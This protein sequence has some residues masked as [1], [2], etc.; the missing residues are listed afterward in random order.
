MKGRR[1]LQCLPNACVPKVIYCRMLQRG[2]HRHSTLCFWS[3]A[4]RSR[5]SYLI[6]LP[7]RMNAGPVPRIRW[8]RSHGRD[9][10]MYLAVSA[11]VI[12]I[13]VADSGV[14]S[15]SPVPAF[16]SGHCAA[17]S[18]LRHKCL[19]RFLRACRCFSRSNHGSDNKSYC[20][21]TSMSV[22]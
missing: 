17:L 9:I 5:M 19:V 18:D 16:I 7:I 1:R 12:L 14:I 20:P 21:K 3:H 10:A 15:V 13:R 2:I 4:S 22:Y 8:S 11:S 6:A